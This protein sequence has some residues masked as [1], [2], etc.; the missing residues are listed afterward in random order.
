MPIKEEQK[1]IKVKGRYYPYEDWMK[2]MEEEEINYI[3]KARYVNAF[4]KWY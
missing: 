1:Q 3:L 2:D 4:F